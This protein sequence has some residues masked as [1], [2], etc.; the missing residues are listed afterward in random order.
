MFNIDFDVFDP[1]REDSQTICPSGKFHA[2]N[3]LPPEE[4]VMT[5]ETL[6]N[7]LMNSIT[8]IHWN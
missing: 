8:K 4:R 6:K 7:T 2:L 1:W 5:S 3:I